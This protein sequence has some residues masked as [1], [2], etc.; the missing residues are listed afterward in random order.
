MLVRSQVMNQGP[1]DHTARTGDQNSHRASFQLAVGA[2]RE[3]SPQRTVPLDRHLAASR[4]P[5]KGMP[6]P[7]ATRQSAGS[8]N[9]GRRLLQRIVSAWR[10]SRSTT[11][12]FIRVE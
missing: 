9:R 7:T 10:T 5:G 8:H 6:P 11:A 3:A 4:G 2:T 1:A 12:E